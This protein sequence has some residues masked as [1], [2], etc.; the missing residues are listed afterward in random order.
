MATKPRYLKPQYL[1]ILLIVAVLSA[2]T[3]LQAEE[4]TTGA[5]LCVRVGGGSGCY[6]SI[7]Q[8]VNAANSGDRI[9]VSA[10]TYNET[11]ELKAGVV[12]Q[13]A[14]AS[15]TII[16]ASGTL[17]VV[18]A[19]NSDVG[20]STIF[21]G[22]T[23][24]GGSSA[25]GAGIY[26]ANAAPTIRNNIITG[27]TATGSGGGLYVGGNTAPIIE[28]NEI[29]SNTATGHGGGILVEGSS[30]AVIRNNTIRD[31]R[32]DNQG[33]GLMVSNNSAPQVT[34]NIIR[35]NQAT[36]GGGVS[37]SGTAAWTFSNN[38]LL[39][40]RAIGSPGSAGGMFVFN[41]PVSLLSNTI[42]G[43]QSAVDGGGVVMTQSSASTNIIGNSVLI[44]GNT[45]TSNVAGRNAGAL[46][47]VAG[48]S[49]TVRNNTFRSNNASG[50]GGAL[51]LFNRVNAVFEGNTID[52]N[53]AINAA[54]AM[55][56]EQ[57]A[58]LF[59]NNQITN[60]HATNYVGGVTIHSSN[61]VIDNN[62]VTGNIGDVWVGGIWVIYGSQPVIRNNV[63]ADNRGGQIGGGIAFLDTP[64][65]TIINN[66][67]TGNSAVMGGG[68]YV[69]VASP[70]IERNYI[71]DN[72]AS[73]FG[74]GIFFSGSTAQSTVVNNVIVG[75][76][77]AISGGAGIGLYRG[78]PTITHNTIVDNGNAEGIY[79]WTNAGD[80]AS[81]AVVQNNIIVGHTS[82][83]VARGGMTISS[84]NNLVWGNGTRNFDGVASHSTDISLDPMLDNRAGRSFTLRAGS[85]AI[86]A[87]WTQNVPADDYAG[88]SRPVNG[89]GRNGAEPD[90]GA[91]EV[92]TTNFVTY[93]SYIATGQTAGRT[94]TLV[95]YNTGTTSANVTV[96]FAKANGTT[97]STSRSIAAGASTEVV[98]NNVGGMSNTA[99]S[100]RI[101]S[102]SPDVVAELGFYWQGYTN[103]PASGRSGSGAYALRATSDAHETQYFASGYF[104]TY[105]DNRLALYNPSATQTANVTIRLIP[106][107]GSGVQTITRAIAPGQ[108]ASVELDSEVTSLTNV[109]YS[110]RVE[111]PGV[112]V[113]A[114][115][116]YAY[117]KRNAT[118]NGTG[119]FAMRGA[120]AGYTRQYF[121]LG[122]NK[123]DAVDA[124]K[125]QWVN[126]LAL[127]NYN[128]Q[129]T[130]VTITFTKLV[131]GQPV[132]V[133][134][135]VTI[136]ANYRYS[137][138]TSSNAA[139]QDVDYSTT[140]Q[141]S[142][143]IV[144]EL[145]YYYDQY[146]QFVQKS[147]GFMM[148]GTNAGETTQ[149]FATG[150]TGPSGATDEFQWVNYM[151]LVNPNGSNVTA[152]ITH[153]NASGTQIAS[154]TKTVPANGRISYR[155]D[156]EANGSKAMD[157]KIYSTKVVSAQPVIAELG[158]YFKDYGGSL[159][160]VGGGFAMR[161]GTP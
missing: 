3:P 143:P 142:L 135:T 43:N 90:I 35:N 30:R 59:R 56:E 94:N 158:I 108:R 37:A 19:L 71:A 140:V 84:R 146:N 91:Y 63:I 124:S 14:G 54:A 6:P 116:E 61:P 8:A 16:S 102:S 44:E 20:N 10:G 120:P 76:G 157:N 121:A 27:N 118:G 133:V 45:F 141:S 110:T 96:L 42:S 92:Q 4:S 129:P 72:S 83:L 109:D 95:L 127:Y 65:S 134:Q 97:A 78:Q 68:L 101:Q 36:Q 29:H 77:A 66:Q 15:T 107:N 104:S 31:N 100:T 122:Y 74:G 86:D 125:E 151:A 80:P 99:Y 106:A 156:L 60:N 81:T 103:T 11:I 21:E 75:N 145:G 22:F 130:N 51:N 126:F 132:N 131:N 150:N 62:T 139:L 7:Q 160:D 82:G 13:G 138:K 111:S 161:G 57:S 48:S 47:L 32:S 33:G 39:N 79:G 64:G 123:T 53:T 49:P 144:A 28:G 69:N 67:I 115:M 98:V 93:D 119:G 89:D 154:Y 2:T 26:I 23:V 147:D 149:F 88:N 38:Q 70:R 52:Q 155:V 136:A 5:V 148:R 114:E 113:V 159:S 87:A 105:W 41:S 152:T 112:P 137:F 18:R 1:V 17:G 40:N 58:P 24:R 128:N 25:K 117:T 12:L 50:D 46:F 55:V 85:P 73:Q 153:Y 9:T 34:G